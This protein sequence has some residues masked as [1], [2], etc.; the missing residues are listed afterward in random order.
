MFSLNRSA[1][2][3]ALLAVLAAG[4]SSVA[5]TGSGAAHPKTNSPAPAMVPVK[6]ATAK[7]S[8]PAA[9]PMRSHSASAAQP[10]APPA[11]VPTQPPAPAPPPAPTTHPAPPPA[12]PIPQHNG[13]DSDG[14]NNNGPS[15]GD[16]NI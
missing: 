16:G 5:H 15:D 7:P 10:A 6:P 12:N 1:A 4:C 11:P 13:G 8:R 14:D 9:R 3:F 2:G